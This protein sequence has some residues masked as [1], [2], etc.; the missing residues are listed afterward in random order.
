MKRLETLSYVFSYTTKQ[1]IIIMVNSFIDV[2]GWPQSVYIC[3][4]TIMWEREKERYEA[5]KMEQEEETF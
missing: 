3:I 2:M 1:S 4:D 5:G